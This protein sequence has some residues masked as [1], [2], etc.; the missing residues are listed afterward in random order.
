MGGIII[1]WYIGKKGFKIGINDKGEM[2]FDI[3]PNKV[4]IEPPGIFCFE[5]NIGMKNNISLGKN[6]AE[7]IL[8]GEF[9]LQ[10]HIDSN[11][12][13]GDSLLQL[14]Q[15]KSTEIK[16]DS[17][18]FTVI[19]LPNNRSRAAKLRVESFN[20]NLS[21]N[22]INKCLFE[23]ATE[24]LNN[25]AVQYCIPISF[26]YFLMFHHNLSFFTVVEK[27][28]SVKKFEGSL[29]EPKCDRRLWHLA[30]GKY[31]KAWL[32]SNPMEKFLNLYLGI[33][34]IR[35]AIKK[36][37]GLDYK[38][39]GKIKHKDFNDPILKD[40]F[41][42]NSNPRFPKILGMKFYN[43]LF[44]KNGFRNL[45]NQAAHAILNT[46]EYKLNTNLDDY[47]DYQAAIQYLNHIYI[48]YTNILV[49]LTL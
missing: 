35:I 28:P 43:I 7:F 12:Y 10:D 46:G 39:E 42:I 48:K 34:S 27:K 4:P 33:E 9:I 2:K 17:G 38:E 41:T 6:M 44:S 18:S 14:E 25:I 49:K 32:S 29:M 19:L 16:K 21:S 40:D 5:G 8:G 30:S 36:E 37:L 45:R 22:E 15:P 31:R 20:V 11:Y 3:N 1:N 13:F 24:V 26:T 47:L 23:V